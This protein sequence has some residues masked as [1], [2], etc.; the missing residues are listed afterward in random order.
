MIRTGLFALLLPSL[1]GAEAWHVE[2]SLELGVENFDYHEDV[3][4][5]KSAHHGNLPTARIEALAVSPSH[6]LFARLVLGYT[7]GT[8]PFDGTDQQGTPITP[9]GD[10]T[11]H[12]TDAELVAGYRR[13][14]IDQL[15]LGVS[16]GLGRRTWD[17]DLRPIGA[18][19]YREDYAWWLFPIT[20][21]LD[22][23]LA[24]GWSATLEASAVVP[25]PG[26]MRLHL[27]DFDPTYA[28]LDIGL[29][30]QV[31]ARLRLR[32]DYAPGQG[33]LHL[34][35]VGTYEESWMRQ[36][37]GTEILVN[38]APT[39]PALY[40]SEPETHTR[41]LSVLAGAGWQF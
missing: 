15:W 1:A 30:N 6:R 38:G 27:S 18:Q 21:Q 35:L 14:V 16:V 39:D 12:M 22:Y 28:D 3:P 7:N 34:V 32:T 24:P 17:R 26:S 8:M 2:P 4:G 23:D 25:T 13:N 5:A 37:P 10:A 9:N 36:G 40:A 33:A 11:G 29:A 20:A 41:R 31:G 19:G